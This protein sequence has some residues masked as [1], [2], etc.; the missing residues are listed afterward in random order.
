MMRI[1]FAILIPATILTFTTDALHIA[2]EGCVLMTFVIA[3]LLA[4]GPA[5]IQMLAPS[6][7]RGQLGAVLML[8]AT[9]LGV[10]TG[11]VIVAALAQMPALA[12]LKGA[13]GIHV[14]V[15]ASL[16]LLACLAVRAVAPV[17]PRRTA[18]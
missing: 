6:R 8:C 2:V 14:G 12:G 17:S 18:E 10:T 13:I 9:L 4:L 7:M 15:C 5:A 11:P 3:A 16:G 1:L